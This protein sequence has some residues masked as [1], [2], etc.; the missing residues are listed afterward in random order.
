[1]NYRDTEKIHRLHQIHCSC[2]L[3]LIDFDETLC[4]FDWMWSNIRMNLPIFDKLEMWIS[5]LRSVSGAQSN[6]GLIWH[7]NLWYLFGFSFC[8]LSLSPF[9]FIFYWLVSIQSI[10]L[11]GWFDFA[12]VSINFTVPG[13]SIKYYSIKW[14]YDRKMLLHTDFFSDSKRIK[15]TNT[16]RMKKNME[17]SSFLMNH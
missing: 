3:Q 15:E 5:S 7:S 17:H 1:M 9:F 14:T 13:K 12:F 6:R 16:K 8:T 2:T 4:S 11:F 10:A